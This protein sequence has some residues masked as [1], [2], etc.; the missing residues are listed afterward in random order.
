MDEAVM[1]TGNVEDWIVRRLRDAGGIKVERRGKVDLMLSALDGPPVAI[2]LKKMHRL[3]E[4]EVKHFVQQEASRQARVRTVVAT[5]RLTPAARARLK[6]AGLSWIEYATGRV[7]IRAPGLAIDLPEDGGFERDSGATG[8]S[9]SV[10]GL[11]GK[12]GLVVEALLL[13]ARESDWVKQPDVARLAG[14][15]QAWASKVLKSLV[16][17]G[18]VTMKG[19]GPKKEWRM[20]SASLLDLWEQDGGTKPEIVT[21]LYVWARHESDL[22]HK[23]RTLHEEGLRYAIGGVVAADLYEPTLTSRPKPEVWLAASVSPSEV[24]EALKGEIVPSGSNLVLWQTSGDPALRLSQEDGLRLVSKPRAYVE[25][26]WGKG[27][28]ADVAEKLR[29]SVI[30]ALA[31]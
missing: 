23:I 29:Q 30:G 10:P 9:L 8:S 13:L 18:A 28:A 26:T 25:S 3:T 17:A 5:R 1:P 6:Q 20:D 27:R 15:T 4:D 12:A 24:A 22:L 2:E 31:A 21:G 7:H 14:V 19:A 16:A 11:A